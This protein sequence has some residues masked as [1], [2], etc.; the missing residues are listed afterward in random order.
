MEKLRSGYQASR[1]LYG[2]WLA[3]KIRDAALGFPQNDGAGRM[4]PRAAAPLPAPAPLSSAGDP[5]IDAEKR[6]AASKVG[7]AVER[8][9]IPNILCLNLRGRRLF[10]NDAVSGVT[11]PDSLDDNFFRRQI[12]LGHDIV[13]VMF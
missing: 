13:S 2:P 8:V 12:S 9:N 3:A 5:D 11:L 7:C 6:Q 1:M 10:R 4:I